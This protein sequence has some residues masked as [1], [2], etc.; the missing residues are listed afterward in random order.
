MRKIFLAIIAFV[1]LFA[2]GP[3]AQTPFDVSKKTKGD[4]TRWASSY[5]NFSVKYLG[6]QGDL[7]RFRFKRDASRGKPLSLVSWTNRNGDTVRAKIGSASV[8]F[9]PHD[10]S[11]T[12]GRCSYVEKHSKLGSRSIIWNATSKNGVWR[13]TKH[14]NSV[15]KATLLQAGTFTVDEFGY[16]IDRDYQTYQD[17]R[18]SE[19]GWTRRV[20]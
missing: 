12:L 8:T 9:S 15:S 16:S 1:L 4:I 6:Q 13:Y 3:T 11:L 2:S 14:L 10:C 18:L 5:G 19:N 20:R 7:F 17:G